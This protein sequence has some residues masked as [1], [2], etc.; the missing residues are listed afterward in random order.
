MK[1]V[2]DDFKELIALLNDSNVEYLI[3]GG[4]AVNLYGYHRPTDDIDI[5]I[6]AS[7][8]NADRLIRVMNQFVGKAPDRSVFTV[9]G[10]ILEFGHPP[11]RVHMM[12]SISG[13]DFDS[14]YARRHAGMLDDVPTWFISLED[15]RRNKHASGRHKDLADLEQI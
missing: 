2:H 15:L 11:M 6:A 1:H 7:E 14:C 9:P 8:E 3:V 10:K 13:V 12:T 4:Y 5:W